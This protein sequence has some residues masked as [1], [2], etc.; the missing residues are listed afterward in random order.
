M[1][2]E[3]NMQLLPLNGKVTVVSCQRRSEGSFG[4]KLLPEPLWDWSLSPAPRKSRRDCQV[5]L[6]ITL[7]L[8][9]AVPEDL[10]DLAEEEK[11]DACFR[12]PWCNRKLRKKNLDK[13]LPKATFT[14]KQ[15]RYM[16][17]AIEPRRI[18][19]NCATVRQ[20]V[21]GVEFRRLKPQLEMKYCAI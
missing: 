15:H 2:E 17:T 19:H 14:A 16:M 8:K 1:V 20:L 3:K 5:T 21:A 7:N 10:E 4:H 12:A 18:A 13:I 9:V 6:V 11:P